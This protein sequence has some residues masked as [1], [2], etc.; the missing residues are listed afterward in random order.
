MSSRIAPYLPTLLLLSGLVVGLRAGAAPLKDFSS[1][2]STTWRTRLWT[3][4][5]RY[6]EPI[7]VLE[8]GVELDVLSYSSSRSWV[9]VRT[10]GGRDGWVPLRYTALSSKRRL[11][12]EESEADDQDSGN[13]RKI[14]STENAN[15]PAADDRFNAAG[16]YAELRGEYANQVSPDSSHG[17]GAGATI[18][19]GW[20]SKF[21]AGLAVSWNH[22]SKTVTG[23][24][25]VTTSNTNR[26]FVGPNFRYQHRLFAVDATLG[27]DMNSSTITNVGVANTRDANSEKAIGFSL[28][29][30]YR[31]PVGIRTSLEIYVAYAIA[32]HSG[33]DTVGGSGSTPQQISLGVAYH[34]PL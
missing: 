31:L 23:L 4:P 12:S 10:P 19:Y 33:L 29:P 17:Y 20:N 6:G 16:I 24:S 15:E 18:G 30:A 11:L 27:L 7:A 14:A 9:K 28:R 8:K 26:I 5:T 2:T 22:F 3:E 13:D 32:F 1:E 21:S 34:I 25:N